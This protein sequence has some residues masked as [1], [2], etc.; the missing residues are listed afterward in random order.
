[1]SFDKRNDNLAISLRDVNKSFHIYDKPHHRLLQSLFRGRKRYYRDFQALENISFDVLKGETVGVIGR[2]GAGKST[3][4]QIICGTM[5]QTSGDIDI[6]GRIAALL[7]LGSGFN[8]EFTGRENVYMNGVVLGLNKDEIERRFDDILAFADIGNFIDQPVKTYS[9][10]MYVRLAFSVSINVDPDI[11]VIDEAL[12]VGDAGFQ[13]KCLKHLEKMRNSGCT[14]LY[15]SHGI[16]SVR[17]FCDRAIWLNA[18]NLVTY[19]EANEVAD[20]YESFIRN[21]ISIQETNSKLKEKPVMEL[22]DAGAHVNGKI[23][24]VELFDSQNKETRNFVHNETVNVRI[25]YEL[26]CEIEGGVVVGCAI[27]RNDDLYVCGVNTKLDNYPIASGEGVHAVVLK[28]PNLKLLSA[29][30]YFKFGLFDSNAIVEWDFIHHALEF[31][32][33]SSYL[34]EG[35]FVLDHVWINENEK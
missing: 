26:S 30:Y 35:V 23:L 32:V 1:M 12:A 8:P 5:T 22:T 27:Y 17:N 33:I 19:S 25:K 10:G 15:V 2:N 29:S 20:L 21:D 24:S 14:I 13:H 3:L 31:K 7:E 11:L 16:G 9:S 4:L 6:N 18:G 34:A 28:M